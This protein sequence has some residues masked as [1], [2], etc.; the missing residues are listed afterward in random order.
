LGRPLFIYINDAAGQRK[1]V[2]DFVSFY[3]A[4]TDELTK[5]VGFI[6]LTDEE[7]AATKAKWDQFVA[8][9]AKTK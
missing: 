9:V 2:Q 3:I 4:H 7:T 1:E 8:S 5:E 6:P